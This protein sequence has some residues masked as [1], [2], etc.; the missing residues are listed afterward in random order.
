MEKSKKK[1]YSFVC[2]KCEYL[3]IKSEEEAKH[4]LCKCGYEGSLYLKKKF[5]KEYKKTLTAQIQK[6][7]DFV[8]TYLEQNNNQMVQIQ[9]KELKELREKKRIG[10]KKK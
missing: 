10:T 2:P 4:I 6:S 9:I 5:L 7:E 8:Q 3:Y 1:T